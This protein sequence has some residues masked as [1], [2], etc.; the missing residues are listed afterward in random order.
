MKRRILAFLLAAGMLLAALPMG[1]LA[2]EDMELTFS[3]DELVQDKSETDEADKSDLDK[4]KDMNTSIMEMLGQ[5]DWEALAAKVRLTGDWREDLV[6]VA[7]SQIGYQEEKDGMTLYTR[8]AGKEKEA[9]EQ[10]IEWTALFVNWV[11]DRIGL[12]SKKFPQ[13]DTYNSL[14]AKMNSVGALKTVSRSSYPTAGDLALIE[15]DGKK[16]VGI[17][18][19]V[20]NSYA[21]MIHGDDNGRVSKETYHVESREF[22]GYVDLNVLMERAGIEVGK[23]GDVPVIPEEGVAAWTNTNAV[24]MRK[25]PTTASKSL[26][27]IKKPRTAVLVTSAE[28]QDDGYIWYGVQYQKYTGYIRGDLLELD[29]AAIPTATPAPTTKPEVTPVPGCSLCNGAALGLALPVECCYEHLASMS[30]DEAASFMNELLRDDPATFVLYVSCVAAHVKAGDADLLCLGKE[31]GSSAW[32]KPSP[33]HAGNCPWHKA[34]LI[35]QERVVNIETREAR[36][37]QEIMISFELYAASTYQWHEVKSVVN[38]DGTVTETD[39]VMPG[40]NAASVI[41]TAKSGENTNYSYYCVATIAANGATIEVASKSTVLSVG[42]APIVAQ[43]ILGEEINFTYTNTR[44]ASYQWYVQA[45]ANAAPVAIS[46]DAAAYTGANASRLTFHATVENS[47]AFYSCAALDKNGQEIGRSGAYSYV[48]NVY[49]SAPDV[50]VCAGHDLCKYVEELA[51]MSSEERYAALTKT[52][53][54]SAD[55]LTAP[56]TAGDCIAEYVMLHWFMCHADRYPNLLCTCMPTDEDRLL[57]HPYNDVHDSEC[58]WYVE[59]VKQS[60]D[61]TQTAKRADQEEFDKWA[62]TATDE[63]I[64]RAKTVP[65]L[66]HAV[67][68]QNGDSTYDLYIARYAE[69]VGSVDADGYLTYGS[70]A[71]VIAWVDFATGTVYA[72]NN[73][74]AHAPVN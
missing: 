57:Y 31:C 44:A 21:S 13:G 46:A 65:T 27:T 30:V 23:G 38:A 35:A 2:E 74:P 4:L 36:K 51:N 37:G 66:D 56:G 33:L 25:E 29:R 42:D 3:P 10:D 26:T 1:A 64:A 63:M 20:A 14:R 32:A 47:G 68:E 70:P 8:W 58:P 28:M 73:L 19:Y 17:V 71:L 24:Y 48:I 72:M 22:K 43:A 59:T 55:D 60:A 18:V 16:L 5:K 39:T 52:W 50:S 7:Q 69:P 12:N 61:E 9:E 45:D 6:N 34:G 15:V 67:F 49:G 62:A 53:Y 41:I 40:E 11:A 54:V